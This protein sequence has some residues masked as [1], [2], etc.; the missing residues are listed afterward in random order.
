MRIVDALLAEFDHEARLTQELLR[1][2][3]EE[4]LSWRPHARS[5]TLGQLA[6][7]IARLPSNMVEL[8][9]APGGEVP[10][11]SAEAPQPAS[12]RQVL[13]EFETGMETA[14]AY[15]ASLDDQ[16]AFTPWTLSHRDEE[17]MTV[18]R[19]AV[20]RALLMNHFIHH[21]GQLSVYLRLLDVPLPVLY[22]AS[23]DENP[24]V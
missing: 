2:L 18:P 20:V 1:R 24:F 6:H 9:R 5:M 11:F 12:V 16:A 21:R 8:V 15:L 7:H 10:D 22:G 23:A 13:E 4:H 14:R 17:M 3:P 19:V